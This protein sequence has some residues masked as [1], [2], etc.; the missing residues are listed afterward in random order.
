MNWMRAVKCTSLVALGA[1]VPAGSGRA[2]E[3]TTPN[4]T[5]FATGLTNPR[6]M[7]FGPDGHLYVAEA[8][9]GGDQPQTCD[10]PGNMF[11]VPGPYLG[12]FTARVSRILPDGTRQTVSDHLPSFHDGFGDALG[13]SDVAW[14]G[15]RM[16]ALVEGGG[17]TRGLPD[18]P[19]GVVRIHDDGSYSYVADITAF[20]RAHPVAQEPQCGPDGDCEPDG[21]PHSM[22]AVGRELYVV[23][24]NHNSVLRVNPWTGR[25]KRLYDLSVQDPAPIILMR[26]ARRFF[27]GGFDGLIQTFD[28]R[29]GPVKPFD[30]GYGPIVD[31]TT[32][33][34]RIHVLETF[35]LETP[36]TPGT[37]RVVRRDRHGR[38]SVVACGLD[39]PIGM[40]RRGDDLFISTVSYGQGP[41][42]G[43]GQ[44]VKI[45]LGRDD[46]GDHGDLDADCERRILDGGRPPRRAGARGGRP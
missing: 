37:G 10:W 28:Q 2:Q 46:D 36:W 26:R 12:G 19:A 17:C 16:Y 33:R 38:H 6:H 35:A 14:I 21:V 15:R 22:L 24:T 25:V 9:I 44:I 43:L 42:E 40:A 29:L 30:D 39:F 4:W 7:R 1:L 34:E 3:C 31:M 8:G 23:E 13:V 18:H 5:V 27:L 11:T 20:I 45:D 32:F 41:V